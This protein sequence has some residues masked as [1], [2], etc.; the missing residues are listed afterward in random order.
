[1]PTLSRGDFVNNTASHIGARI[2]RKGVQ[3]QSKHTRLV[4]DTVLTFNYI[5]LDRAKKKKVVHVT[6][7][8]GIK[9]GGG[10][11]RANT[12]RIIFKPWP[13]GSEPTNLIR[14]KIEPTRKPQ[15]K[16]SGLKI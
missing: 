15:T 3:T 4:K 12:Y 8:G 1:M 14:V 13:K 2:K 7:N 16:G 11:S 10:S 5:R 9:E 6:Y